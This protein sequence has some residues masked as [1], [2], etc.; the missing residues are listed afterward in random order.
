[1]S[2]AARAIIHV[3]RRYVAEEWGGTETVIQEISRQ[4]QKAGWEPRII[5]SMALSR[6]RSEV[7]GGVSVRRWPHVYPFL[8]LSAADRAALD[9]KG[10]NLLSLSLFW[11]LL[12]EPRVRLFH[13]H[14]LKRLGGEV[15]TAARWRRLPF[16]VSLHGGVFD[17]P[18][19]ELGSMLEPIAN[20][21]EWG[22][23][24]GALFGSRKVLADAD[25]VICV[26]RGEMERARVELGDD[27]VWHLPNGV[28][29]ARFAAGDGPGF[30]ARHGIAPDAFLILCVGRI[31]A[32]KNQKLLLTAFVRL[33]SRIPNAVVALMGPE[34]QPSYAAAL[35]EFIAANSLGPRAL[36][37][38]GLRNDNPELVNAYHACDV[39]ALPSAHEPFGIVVLEAWSAGK[40]VV[41]SAVG[42]LAGLIRAGE[43]GLFI[44]REDS[45]PGLAGSLERLAAEPGERRR[46]GENGRREARGSYDWSVIGARLEEIYQA[47]ESRAAARAGGG[48]TGKP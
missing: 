31:D 1:M 20:K 12:R 36:L 4:Q 42:G 45:G 23:F 43:T 13:A 47:A 15:R 32:Q 30:R 7:I 22:R 19:S 8:G 38:P 46:L 10:G 28:D 29:C 35:R 25:A 33:A 2:I 27:R 41:A 5:T 16:V 21:P 9:K 34:T 26:G 48:P 11:A 14:A 24:F 39:F 44:D 3:P 18:A 37:L 6:R 40:A 17:V